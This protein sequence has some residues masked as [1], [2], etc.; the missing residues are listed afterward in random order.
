MK[1]AAISD[2]CRGQ[3]QAG[4]CHLGWGPGVVGPG[5]CEREGGKP[6]LPVA[7]DRSASCLLKH[8]ALPVPRGELAVQTRS[9]CG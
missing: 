7:G 9:A 8:E 4:P 3:A 5:G 6:L 1:V 2:S